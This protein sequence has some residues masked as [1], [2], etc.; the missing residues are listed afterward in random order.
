MAYILIPLSSFI[1][2]VEILKSLILSLD[3]LLLFCKDNL[4]SVKALLSRFEII[5]HT[6]GLIAN[7]RKSDL[8]FARVNQKVKIGILAYSQ[9]QEGMPFRYLGIPLT[10]KRL[11]IA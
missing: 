3:D 4:N 8:Y 5:S 10:T 7:T 11:S 2:T 9:L 6:S 1:L